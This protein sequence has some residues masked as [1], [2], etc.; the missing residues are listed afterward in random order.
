MCLRSAHCRS[1]TLRTLTAQQFGVA[2]VPLQRTVAWR[3][4]LPLKV[5]MAVVREALVR[6]MAA[7]MVVVKCMVGGV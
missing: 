4:A 5:G 2:A 7:M 3:L 1:A 6:A